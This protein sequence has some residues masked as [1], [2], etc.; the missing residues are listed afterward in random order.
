MKRISSLLAGIFLVTSMLLPFLSAHTAGAIS[1]NLIANPLVETANPSNANAPLGWQS[2]TWGT[3]TTS[4]SYLKSGS[5]GDTNSVNLNTTAYTSGD[6]EWYFTPVSVTAGS[7]YTYSDYYQSTAVSEVD[8]AYT[9][10]D[11]TN[12]YV[13]LNTIPASAT[14]QQ[15][16]ANFTVPSG[17]VSATVYHLLYSDGSLTTD[18]FSLTTSTT[19]NTPVV[20]VTAPSANSSVSGTAVLLTATASDS[21]GIAS[22]QF[23]V[24]GTNVGTALTTSPYQYS[25]DSTKTTNGTHSVTAIATAIGGSTA[26]SSPLSITVSNSLPQ[27]S[28]TVPNPLL[29]TANPSNANAP[30]DWQSSSWGTNTTSFSY[31]KSGSSGDTNSVSVV[32]TAYASGAAE[33]LYTPQ[34]VTPGSL[35][36]FSDY[37]E[38][39]IATNVE[40]EFTSTSGTLTYLS[41]GSPAASTSWKQYSA[42]FTVPAGTKSATV[43]QYLNAVGSLTTDNY[44]LASSTAPSVVITAPAAS[45]ATSTPYSGNITLSASASA[46]A[47]VASVQFK[48]DNSNVGT[49]VTTSPYQYVWNSSALA[50]GTHLVTAVVTDKAG[51]S[52]T[53]AAVSINVSNG[54]SSA[55]NLI[56][57]PLLETANP[58]IPTEPLDYSAGT[59]GTNSTTF[60]Y[61]NSGSTGDTSSVE[62][63]ITSYTSGSSEW[64]PNAQPVVPDQQYK[65]SDYYKTNTSSEVDASVYMSDGSIDYEIL[66]LPTPSTSWAQ[67]G[68]TFTIPQ[69][70]QSVSVYQYISGVGY[71][72][73]DNYSLTAYKPVGFSRPLLTLTFDDG[74]GD[75]YTNGLPLLEQYGFDSTQFIITDAIGDS[76]YMTSAQIKSLYTAGNEIASHT[77]T[78]DN[79]TLETS[80]QLK[81]EL[82]QSQATLK[83]ITG[84]A[85]TGFAYPYG[86]YNTSVISAVKSYY[87]AARGVESGL[88]SKDNYNAYDLK[89]ED[90]YDTTTTAQVADWVAQAQATDTW[91]I[92]VYHSVDSNNAST[93]DGGQYNV[94]PTQ[95]GAQLAAIK[96]SGIIVETMSKAAAEINPQL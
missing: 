88:N 31:L 14:W 79:L 73:T 67:F 51:N 75:T 11:G 81:T 4:F 8:V 90:V 10:S 94:T 60:S 64:I 36:N 22:V 23:Q 87:S 63:Q 25:W 72:T 24:D 32:T 58:N 59:Y 13:Y 86:L 2:S 91:L 77:V 50:N 48:V 34:A 74:Y 89:V 71:I 3:N 12:Q 56:A 15:Y 76:G 37:Y 47:G 44:S 70:A 52:A 30:L 6:S 93:F 43:Y 17:A 62:A 45:T 38:S 82:S 35:Y 21:S 28:N 65:F 83:S 39:S 92:L 69:G 85:I 19:A 42:S 80:A 68:T 66:G 53:S 61:L 40:A 18:N 78:H 26:T 84:T 20:S 41:L 1:T 9:M 16:S 57:N 55:T 29:E 54:S 46:A 33:W 96:A 27:G 5:S 7:S 95:L 49:A